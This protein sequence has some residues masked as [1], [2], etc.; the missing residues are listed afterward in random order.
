MI[1]TEVNNLFL[2][3]LSA[4]ILDNPADANLFKD[5]DVKTWKEIE[6]TARKQSVNA[7]IADKVL[8]LPEGCLPPKDMV[9]VFISQVEQTKALNRKMINVFHKLANEHQKENLPFVLLKG[10]SVGINYP[11]PLLRNPGDIDLLLYYKGAY[12][13]SLKLLSSKGIKTEIGDRIHYKYNLDGVL[14][15]NHSRAI[16]FDN[17]K[18]YKIFLKWEELLTD[19]ENFTLIDIDGLKVK[20]LPVEMNALFIFFHMFK[21]FAHSGVGF[22]QYCDW[23]LFLSKYHNVI[24]IASFTNI[25]K[26]YALLYPMQVF[27]RAAVKYLNVPESIFPFK[28][29]VEDKH[30]DLVIEDI[31]NSGN[32]GFHY[33]GK[34]RPTENR[35]R[36]RWFVFK[37]AIKKSIKFGSLSH[38]HIRLMPM[39]MVINRIKLG[40]K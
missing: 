29:I 3:L 38:E 12:E 25:S 5:L 37:S 22:R 17:R 34:K 9:M 7:L 19:T 21:H 16:F 20:Q 23:L 35:T 2:N 36:I 14:V 39:W 4:A 28:M 10:L 27:A 30:V 13:R 6:G 15:E 33:P 32:F 11:D 40:L 1:L 18:Y 26:H 24:D 8:S 31:F